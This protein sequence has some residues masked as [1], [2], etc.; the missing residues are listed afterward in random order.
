M[1]SL[2]T[3]SAHG[4]SLTTSFRKDLITP[5]FHALIFYFA[6][7]VIS[8]NKACA[9]SEWKNILQ[10]TTVATSAVNGCQSHVT[11]VRPCPHPH[12]SALL[13]NQKEFLE[14]LPAKWSASEPH[15][16]ITSTGTA[17]MQ[18]IRE[19]LLFVIEQCWHFYFKTDC[20]VYILYILTSSPVV[21]MQSSTKRIST[22]CFIANI[23]GCCDLYVTPTVFCFVLFFYIKLFVFPTFPTKS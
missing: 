1:F 22:H 8:Q 14:Q 15:Y 17:K 21:F 5:D 18:M 20:F 13:E 16:L 4:S 3:F 2:D 12:P 6:K 7:V 10:S 23:S 11:D 19:G 9:G